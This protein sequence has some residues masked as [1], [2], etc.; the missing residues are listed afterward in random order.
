MG[1][2]HCMSP[3]QGLTCT[4]FESNWHKPSYTQE[5]LSQNLKKWKI[6]TLKNL[7]IEKKIMSYEF[8]P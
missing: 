5:P 8:K 1:Y 7:K 3:I 6:K 2:E 4:P